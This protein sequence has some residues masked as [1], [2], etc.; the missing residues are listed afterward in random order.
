MGQ[1]EAAEQVEE[2]L[3]HLFDTFVTYDETGKLK[4]FSLVLHSTLDGT[5]DGEHGIWDYPVRTAQWE[6]IQ[7]V[8]NEHLKDAHRG[9]ET[10]FFLSF[11]FIGKDLQ[12][13]MQ[14]SALESGLI[15]VILAFFTLL[16]FTD[17]LLMSALASMAILATLTLV[18]GWLVAV[19][20]ISPFPS[21]FLV[22][23]TDQCSWYRLGG[24]LGSSRACAWPSQWAYA[25]ISYATTRTPTVTATRTLGRTG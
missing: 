18:I 2:L 1:A 21:H 20:C 5:D 8:F 22:R 24:G 12:D 25:W 23:K 11:G 15:A 10:G 19:R 17:D 9:W 14:F 3:E 7:G 13:S 16:A 6:E 4:S